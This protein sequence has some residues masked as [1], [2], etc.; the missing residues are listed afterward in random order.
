MLV[1]C[2][3]MKGGAQLSDHERRDTSPGTPPD[4]LYSTPPNAAIKAPAQRVTE[5]RCD[6]PGPPLRAYFPLTNPDFPQ[7][8]PPPPPP[9]ASLLSLCEPWFGPPY[10]YL[11]GTFITRQHGANSH[12]FRVFSIICP[13]HQKFVP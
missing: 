13:K 6:V 10:A 8:R 12:F 2:L 1:A 3:D 7:M 4:T 5:P 9:P 11:S